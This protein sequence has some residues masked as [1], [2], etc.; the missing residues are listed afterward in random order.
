VKRSDEVAKNLR[1]KI[2]KGGGWSCPARGAAEVGQPPG[3]AGLSVWQTLLMHLM[4]FHISPEQ[5]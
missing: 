5:W 2:E 3:I 4:H 1:E